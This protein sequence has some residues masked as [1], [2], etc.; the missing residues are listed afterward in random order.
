LPVNDWLAIDW[1]TSNVRLWHMRGADIVG[2]AEGGAGMGKIAAQDYPAVLEGLIESAGAPCGLTAIVCGMAGARG[3]WR[4]AGYLDV[5]C[6]L[7]ALAQR[8]VAVEGALPVARAFIL[9][10]VCQRA[11]GLEDVMRGEETQIA[12]LLH[13]KPDYDGVAVLPGTHNKWVRVAGGRILS[14]ATVMTGELFGI[15]CEHSILRL[16][17]NGPDDAAGEEAGLAEGLKAG[18][19]APERLG[20]NLFRVRAGALLSGREPAWSK[21][22]L[23]G[24]LVGSEV[25]GMAKAMNAGGLPV[26]LIG[27]TRLV[28][29]YARALALTGAR[30]E[31][32]PAERSVVQ[33][34]LSAWRHLETVS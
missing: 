8:A 19:D 12:G 18:L 29:I 26:T 17:V 32:F 25:A 22:Y 23:S 27:A 16:S 6:A 34:L 9:P 11:A 1:G 5:P 20:A 2:H 33:G 10:G 13:E 14:F 3:A 31:P 24:L 30:G 7:D 28:G 4:E 15:M 21:G